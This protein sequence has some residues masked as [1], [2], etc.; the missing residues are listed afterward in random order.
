MKTIPQTAEAV[1]YFETAIEEMKEAL[2]Q[3]VEQDEEYLSFKREF[4]EKHKFCFFYFKDEMC[5][6]FYSAEDGIKT[7]FIITKDGEIKFDD[8]TTLEGIEDIA[9]EAQKITQKYFKEED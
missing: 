8:N 5:F 3:K 4:F 7:F 9:A 2:Y 6:E 1:K